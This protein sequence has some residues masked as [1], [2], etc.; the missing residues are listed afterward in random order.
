VGTNCGPFYVGYPYGA[1]VPYG[2]GRHPG[3]DFDI[4]KGTP[5]I[6]DSAGEIVYL[7]EPL[8][9]EW[10]SGGISVALAHGERIGSYYAHLT[11]VFVK[12]GQL[13]KR[14]QLIGLSGA[15]NSGNQHLHYGI[16]KRRE[17][18]SLYS[19]T[20]DPDEYWLEGGPK[21]FNP[22]IDYSKYSNEK[23]TLPVACEEYAK[24]LISKIKIKD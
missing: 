5:I 9:N 3:I 17:D 8:P 2:E 16:Y 12:N 18:A 22:G 1:R 7:E 10:W 20:Y 24:E 19:K 11:N 4:N 21:C 14:G 23:M 15:N 6:A 13:M